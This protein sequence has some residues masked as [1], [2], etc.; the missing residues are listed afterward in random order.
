MYEFCSRQPPTRSKIQKMSLRKHKKV[1]LNDF[2]LSREPQVNIRRFLYV[3]W[4]FRRRLKNVL[5]LQGKDISNHMC[6]CLTKE[7]K[8]VTTTF[9]ERNFLKNVKKKCWNQLKMD[10]ASFCKRPSTLL[11]VTKKSSWRCFFHNFSKSDIIWCKSIWKFGSG[12]NNPK[13]YIYNN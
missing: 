8:H 10:G 12:K 13:R 9:H 4:M 11:S 5:C 1:E 7:K 2:V 6:V 3:I